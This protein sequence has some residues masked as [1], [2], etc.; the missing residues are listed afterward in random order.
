MTDFESEQT[1]EPLIELPGPDIPEEPS[2]KPRYSGKPWTAVRIVL[3]AFFGLL[4]IIAVIGFL[5]IP[6]E[7]PAVE[8]VLDEFMNAMEVRDTAAAKALFVARYG[9]LIN[10]SD[11]EALNDSHDNALF[12]G[13][14]SLEIGEMSLQTGAA[15][16]PSLPQGTMSEVHAMIVYEG[17][18]EGTI[19]A[20]LEKHDNQWRIFS[21]NVWVPE[22]KL[23]P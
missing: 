2:K 8:A 6:Q 11:L 17:G 23:G 1:S 19:E 14:E 22:E 4:G 16:D 10:E 15:S 12:E 21:F 18:Y 3:V 7:M 5:R 20:L 9:V 13:Y